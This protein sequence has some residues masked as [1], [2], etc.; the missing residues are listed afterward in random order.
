[1]RNTQLL[2][3]DD[4]HID[5]NLTS[6]DSAIH[7]VQKTRKEEFFKRRRGSLEELGDI[8]REN[9]SK[10]TNNGAEEVDFLG[11]D[12]TQNS[13]TNLLS[14]EMDT[15]KSKSKSN[16]GGVQIDKEEIEK[17]KKL[18]YKNQKRFLKFEDKDQDC[19]FLGDVKAFIYEYGQILKNYK[20]I[21]EFVEKVT[22][23]E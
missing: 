16:S 17:V 23:E 19:I 5:Y 22:N 8:D 14:L 4:G 6:F 13:E 2:Q 20:K 18:L 11:L 1:M 21:S 12:I 7:F 15:S 9:R 3:G 10:A